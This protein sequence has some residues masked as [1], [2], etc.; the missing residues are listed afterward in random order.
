MSNIESNTIGKNESFILDFLRA[1][2]AQLVLISHGITFLIP[3][4]VYKTS[5]FIGYIAPFGVIIFFLLS[6]YLITH[7][8][9]KK[10]FSYEGFKIFLIDRFSRIYT[11]FIPC[12]ILIS[13]IDWIN[14]RVFNGIY[15]NEKATGI[16]TFLGNLFM[17]QN[18]PS[19]GVDMHFNSFLFGVDQFV[20]SALL[21]GK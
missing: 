3:H 7:S 12:L 17:L 8:A 13:L 18:R 10:N 16:A 14:I 20:K 5:R 2:T 9:K 11:P 1:I 19:I 15:L 6:G 4:E 21:S